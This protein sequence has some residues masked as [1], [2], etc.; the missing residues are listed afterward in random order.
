[1]TALCSSWAGTSCRCYETVSL[2]CGQ[3]RA[4]CPCPRWCT[5]ME[6]HGGMILTGENQK[7][8]SEEKTCPGTTFSITDY[9]WT[10]PGANLVFRGERPKPNRLSH[11][12]A[13]VIMSKQRPGLSVFSESSVSRR[14][15]AT[16]RAPS[17]V[18]GT[19][20]PVRTRVTHVDRLFR[21]YFVSLLLVS[22]CLQ[23]GRPGFD[24]RQRQRIFPLASVSR[25]AQGPT[26]S[27]VQ[28]TPGILSPGLKRSGRDPDHSP[29]STSEVKNE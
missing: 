25:P 1:M 6:K 21:F 20:S 24:P 12:T 26:Q 28:W 2:N 13:W 5:S 22:V 18:C 10:D 7:K 3:Q 9:T 19:I 23:T 17:D 4:C 11:R 8:N 16:R 14:V 27:P 15:P 29:K